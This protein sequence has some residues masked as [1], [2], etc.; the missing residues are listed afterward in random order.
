MLRSGVMMMCRV[1]T[2]R[3][4]VAVVLLLVLE[5]HPNSAAARICSPSSPLHLERF[6]VSVQSQSL[7]AYS[8][9]VGHGSQKGLHFWW[10]WELQYYWLNLSFRKVM[11]Y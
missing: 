3:N 6:S 11:N 9:A 7:M 4:D 1:Q 2:A 8:D 5:I 10:P